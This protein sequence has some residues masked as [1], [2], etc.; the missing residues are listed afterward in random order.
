MARLALRPRSVDFIENLFKGP[1]GTLVVEDIEVA[2]G[3]PLVGLTVGDVQTRVPHVSF[4]AVLRNGQ[5][6]APLATDFRVAGGDRIAAVGTED[7]LQRLEA[8]SQDVG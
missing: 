7:T 4:V 6:I 1:S 3:S 5:A 2:P 8:A